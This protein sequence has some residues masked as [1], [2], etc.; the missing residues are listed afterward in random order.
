M[1]RKWCLV[2]IALVASGIVRAQDVS[3]GAMPTG[4][5]VSFVV[6]GGD[7][8]PSYQLPTLYVFA[9]LKF[10]NKR[11]AR[12]Y[13]KLVR[14][15]K[16]VLPI[17]NEVYQMV[18]ETYEYLQTLPDEK[19]KD[20]HIKAVEKSIKKQYTPRMKKLTLSQGK[21]LIKLVDRQCNQPSYELVKAFLG[22]LRAGVYQIFAGLFGASLKREY[23]PEGEDRLIE[24]AVLMVQSGQ[25]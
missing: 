6:D 22:P 5:F 1:K 16:I 9:P 21:L 24:R 12:E 2:L 19:A 11:Q 18:I 25:A 20:K 23:D 4:K 14:N 17:A 15:V 8:I 3:S 10:K 7:T 13:D